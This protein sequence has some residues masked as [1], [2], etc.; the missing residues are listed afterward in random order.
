MR[1]FLAVTLTAELQSKVGALIDRFSATSKGIKWVA[2]HQAHF[3]LF[4]LGEQ[5]RSLVAELDPLLKAEA[6]AH[7]PFFL[8]LGQGGTFPSRQNPRV[9]WLGV[10]KGQAELTALAAGVTG[11]CR[12]CGLPKPVQRFMPHLTL[13][14]VKTTPAVFDRALLER[15]T[16][17]E[18]KVDHFTLFVSEL[19]PQGPLYRE[20]ATYS[21]GNYT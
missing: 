8:S 3:T 19:R 9:L 14:R 17:G 16:G 7:H 13:G 10:E 21:L 20:L 15:G 11:V 1:L 2:P 4:F 6:A 18:M 12:Q 5:P